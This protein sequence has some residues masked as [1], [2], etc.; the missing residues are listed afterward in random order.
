MHDMTFQQARSS[1]GFR[2]DWGGS[3]S[4]PPWNLKEY[5]TQCIDIK[6]TEK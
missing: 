1:G 3:I 5:K 4:P 2:G 6:C